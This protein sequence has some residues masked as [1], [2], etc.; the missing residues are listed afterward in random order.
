MCD[1]QIF[2]CRIAYKSAIPK[3]AI[4]E[5]IDNQLSMKRVCTRWVLKLLT[6][7]QRANRVDCCQEL[8]QESEDN[9]FHSVVTG[10]EFWIRHYDSPSQL[11][12]KIR[13]RS[14]EQIPIR[15]HPERSAGKMTVRY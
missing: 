5:I 14:G 3:T 11:E 7:I 10:D 8:L 12:A 9:F 4:H 2:V 6:P 1:R 13:K 15:L